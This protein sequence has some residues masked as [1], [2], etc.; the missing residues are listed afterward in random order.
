MSVR[1]LNN[2]EKEAIRKKRPEINNN[3]TKKQAKLSK[4]KF[5]PTFQGFF[6]WCLEAA[7][8]ECGKPA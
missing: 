1:R 5:L 7:K 4:E 3:L 8:Y 2:R 6:S